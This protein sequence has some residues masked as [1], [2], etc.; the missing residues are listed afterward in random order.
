M[1]NVFFLFFCFLSVITWVNYQLCC[2]DPVYNH[3]HNHK[4]WI[5][6][7]FVSSVL[8]FHLAVERLTVSS[9]ISA[10]SSVLKFMKNWLN[11]PRNCTPGTVFHPDVLDL[12]FLPHLKQSAKLSYILAIERSVDPLIIELR[13]SILANRSDISST[14]LDCLSAAK[15]S[16]SLCNFQEP[17]SPQLTFCSH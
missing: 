3:N 13:H 5:L 14:V 7:N 4:I 10:Q 12:P 17:C 8:H 1:L 9:I 6:K 11:L 16:H 15:A 2:L